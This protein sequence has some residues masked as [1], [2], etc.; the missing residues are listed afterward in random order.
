MAFAS[1]RAEAAFKNLA[2]KV[3]ERCGILEYTLK[4]TMKDRADEYFAR[5]KRSSSSGDTWE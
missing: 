1:K 4:K 5:L 3:M 2:S